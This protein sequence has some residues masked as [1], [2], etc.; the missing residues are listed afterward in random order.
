MICEAVDGEVNL[1]KILMS[2]WRPERMFFWPVLPSLTDMISAKK[3]K[4]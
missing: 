4:P 1:K 3:S 2:W